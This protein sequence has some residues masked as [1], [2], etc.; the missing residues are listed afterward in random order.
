MPRKSRQIS[1]TGI[2]HLMARGINREPIFH[3]DSDRLRYLETLKRISN[4]S[5][6][7]V[8]GYCLMDNHVHILLKEGETGISKIMHR[9]GASYAYYYNLK[10]ERVGHVFQN[11]F[12]SETIKDEKYL[13]T[14]IRYIHNN[15]VKA[16]KKTKAEEYRWSSCE[17]YYGG[18]DVLPGLTSV[19]YIL[20]LFCENTEQAMKEMQKFNEMETEDQCLEENEDNNEK[21]LSDTKACQIIESIVGNRPFSIFHEISKTERDEVLR[22]LKVK[23]LSI[24]QIS[25]LTGVSFNIVKRA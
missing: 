2:Y 11:R 5:D 20:S 7:A 24:R 14:V 1:P 25:R 23:G 17:A 15:P 18:M 22:R 19:D 13:L 8:F 12:R 21:V 9:L 3:D 10:Y 6:A 16:G 4:E